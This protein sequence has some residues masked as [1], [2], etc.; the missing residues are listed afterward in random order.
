MKVVVDTSVW[1]LAF[2]RRATVVSKHVDL[3]TDLIHDGRVVLLGLVR[4]ELL[5]GI[6][7]GDQFERLRTQLRA[8]P[9]IEMETADHEVAAAHFN[10]CM[11]AGIQGSTID[12]L[13]CAYASRRNYQILSTDPDFGFFAKH[14]PVALLTF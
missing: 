10:T 8:F 9:E 2:R 1:S 14:I 7:H 3:L 11:A 6:R 13:I 5:S 4:Q 12:F